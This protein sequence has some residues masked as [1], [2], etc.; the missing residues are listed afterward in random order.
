MSNKKLKTALVWALV[1]AGVQ[2]PLLIVMFVALIST[3]DELAKHKA[4]LDV[5]CDWSGN[6]ATCKTGLNILK[7]MSVEDI[8]GFGL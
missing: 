2:V 7:S 3:S 4:I 5:A 6:K 1:F 8:R